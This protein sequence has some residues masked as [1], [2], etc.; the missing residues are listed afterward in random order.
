MVWSKWT[1]GREPKE[2]SEELQALDKIVSPNDDSDV[3]TSNAY[4]SAEHTE[5]EY[6]IDY[7][8]REGSMESQYISA[9]TSHTSYWSSADIAMFV[10]THLF[11]KSSDNEEAS[12]DIFSKL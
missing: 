5:L 6:R 9:I 2:I 11:P 7:V 4:E 10:L 12:E 3:S 8:L 1:G